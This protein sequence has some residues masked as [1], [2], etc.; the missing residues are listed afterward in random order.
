[1]DRLFM[2]IA[3]GFGAGY[4]PKAPGT[5]GSLLAL[6][7]HFFLSKLAPTHYALAL[8]GIFFLGVITAGQAEKILDRKDPGVIVIDEVIGMLITLIGAP[9]NPLIWLLGFGIFRF[10]DIFKPYPIRIIDQRINGG[11]GIVLDDVLAGI[12]SCIV[13]QIFCYAIIV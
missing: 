4:L 1:M 10:F 2:T 11:M 6:P 5:W 7:L 8:G 9:N 12:Y 13:L 3:T